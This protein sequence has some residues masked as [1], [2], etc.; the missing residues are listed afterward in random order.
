MIMEPTKI[1]HEV[2]E[3]LE[4]LGHGAVHA[5]ANIT[6]GGIS[7]NLPRVLPEN[8]VCEID[9][10]LI[11]TPSWMQELCDMHDVSFS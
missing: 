4:K 2:P 8:V 1:Y 7:G 3:L 5:L 6:G 11:P 10:K 9:A